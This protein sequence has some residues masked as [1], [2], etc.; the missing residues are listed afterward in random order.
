M[1]I[2]ASVLTVGYA[3]D[4]KINLTVKIES[5][6]IIAEIKWRET[7]ANRRIHSVAFYAQK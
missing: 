7:Y 1:R 3:Q 4:I 5:V 6:I 2:R